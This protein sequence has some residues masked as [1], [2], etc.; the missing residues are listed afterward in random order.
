MKAM[1]LNELQEKKYEIIRLLTVVKLKF[2][3][4]RRIGGEKALIDALEGAANET[5][6]FGS[7]PLANHSASLPFEA[8]QVLAEELLAFCQRKDRYSKGDCIYLRTTVTRFFQKNSPQRER[9]EILLKQ[10]EEKGL[11]KFEQWKAGW[12]TEKLKHK[13]EREQSDIL[14]KK[15]S[16]LEEW[17]STH[18]SPKP[19]FDVDNTPREEL[20]R[21]WTGCFRD[22]KEGSKPLAGTP[23]FSEL[24][25]VMNLDEINLNSLEVTE[26]RYFPYIPSNWILLLSERY[27][28][29]FCL[30]YLDNLLTNSPKPAKQEA[31]TRK[32]VLYYWFLMEANVIPDIRGSRKSLEE[33]GK[34]QSLKA[35]NFYHTFIAVNTGRDKNPMKYNI[36]K[37]VIPMLEEYPEARAKAELELKK[38][39]KE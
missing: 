13:N 29:A 14:R 35:E 38:H 8:Q 5:S 31:N 12:L 32:W 25:F 27:F 37:Q 34:K 23:E 10:S 15:Y 19:L 33:L 30:E 17:Y 2:Y 9:A 22:W 21:A 36:L 20:L 1:N 16:D 11:A 4:G 3:S 6:E 24:P 18:R 39:T 7:N 26:E 28:A